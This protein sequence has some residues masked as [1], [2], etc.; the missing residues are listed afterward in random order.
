M[1]SPSGP[2]KLLLS[3]D[4]LPEHEEA[5][6][7]YV[8]GEFVP[9]LAQAGLPMCEA[10]LTAYGPYPLRLTGFLAR[11]LE[12]LRSVLASPTFRSLETRLQQYVVNYRRRIMP[13]RPGFQF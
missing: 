1:D 10:W 2:V 8:L 7:R 4:P 5:Y 9:A 11:D 3:Y 6:F 12:A 13:A